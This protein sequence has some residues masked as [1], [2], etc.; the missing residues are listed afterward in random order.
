MRDVL[1][2]EAAG[3][4][5]AHLALDVY[6]HR[7]RKYIGAYAAALAGL[8]ALVFTAGVGENSPVIRRRCTTGLGFLGLV[9]DDAA[10]DAGVGPQA[11]QDIAAADAPARIYVVP[12]D[13]ELTIARDTRAI[14][15]G[16]A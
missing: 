13:E 12:T 8:D 15:P 11:P 14:V 10:N 2:A 16:T 1:A 7:I 3:H 4:E 5:R 9:L 6:C